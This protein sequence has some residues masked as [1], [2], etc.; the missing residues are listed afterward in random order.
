MVSTEPVSL[1]TMCTYIFI[2]S[3]MASTEPA[4]LDTMYPFNRSYHSVQCSLPMWRCPNTPPQVD[5]RKLMLD[6]FQMYVDDILGAEGL[7]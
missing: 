1:D 3:S 6:P 4:S 2:E 7:L 5:I